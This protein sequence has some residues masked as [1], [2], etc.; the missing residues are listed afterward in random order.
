MKIA[1]IAFVAFVTLAQGEKFKKPNG[2]RLDVNENEVRVSFKNV[3]I[4]KFFSI[5]FKINVFPI[6]NNLF[7]I[8]HFYFN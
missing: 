1:I 7:L 5:K 2:F 4:V 8:K 3:E 6:K